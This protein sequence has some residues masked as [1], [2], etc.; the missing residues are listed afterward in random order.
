MSEKIEATKTQTE[1]LREEVVQITDQVESAKTDC[2]HWK[3]KAEE[4]QRLLRRIK[5]RQSR[6]P[7][8]IHNAVRSALNVLAYTSCMRPL[9]IPDRRITG[10]VNELVNELVFTWRLPT[11]MVEGIIY[12]VVQATVDVCYG[13]DVDDVDLEMGEHYE[14]NE[15]TNTSAS[16]VP[17]A[18]VAGPSNA[19]VPP[20]V[21]PNVEENA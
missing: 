10:R 9:S 4:I 12:S 17:E 3:D 21:E 6:G 11:S 20:P 14:F 18:V 1:E 5:S 15:P 19:V 8:A 16:P 7:K 2:A 13:G